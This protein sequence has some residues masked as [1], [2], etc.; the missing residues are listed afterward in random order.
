MSKPMKWVGMFKLPSNLRLVSNGK[1][2]TD[3]LGL[4]ANEGRKKQAQKQHA[5][6]K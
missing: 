1:S 5:R 3:T 6:D 4:I 2:I